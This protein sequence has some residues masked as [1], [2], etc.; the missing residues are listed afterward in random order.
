MYFVFENFCFTFVLQKS[1]S[2]TKV[3][4][5]KAADKKPE[6]V[7]LR[8]TANDHRDNRYEKCRSSPV[9]AIVTSSAPASKSVTSSASPDDQ[10]PIKRRPGR[11]VTQRHMT[12]PVTGS[13]KKDAEEVD[14][15]NMSIAER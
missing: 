1:S 2:E 6:G 11:Q 8:P 7:N 14:M 5:D 3:P 4:T 12:Q 10:Q 15:S 9:P 13:E